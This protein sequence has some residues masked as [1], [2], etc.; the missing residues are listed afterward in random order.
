MGGCVNGKASK[1]ALVSKGRQGGAV[2]AR[3]ALASVIHVVARFFIQLEHNKSMQQRTKKTTTQTTQHTDA[4]FIST[5][6]APVNTPATPGPER[7][8]KAGRRKTLLLICCFTCQRSTLRW[9][10]RR[11]SPTNIP[12][13]TYRVAM[14]LGP[15]GAANRPLGLLAIYCLSHVLVTVEGRRLP[16]T[17]RPSLRRTRRC[18]L[19]ARRGRQWL[20]PVDSHSLHLPL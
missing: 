9:A 1:R 8:R 12:C 18:A 15:C 13:C 5:K 6:L 7:K 10:S 20:A 11:P 17:V 14:R 4:V 2:G 16:S 3:E 19:R